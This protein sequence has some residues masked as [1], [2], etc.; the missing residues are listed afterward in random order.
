VHTCATGTIFRRKSGELKAGKKGNFLK[1]K[2]KKVSKS[3]KKVQ[4]KTK[5]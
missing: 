4:K 2:R 1:K 5:K 3:Q